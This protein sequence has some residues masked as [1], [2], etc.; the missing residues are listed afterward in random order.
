MNFKLR[1]VEGLIN[2]LLDKLV[3]DVFGL[4][5][6]LY[7]W[8]GILKKNLTKL[9]NCTS[10]YKLTS[11]KESTVTMWR[12]GST[13]VSRGSDKQMTHSFPGSVP[14]ASPPSNEFPIP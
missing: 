11:T 8:F 1:T 3:V 6:E 4:L 13:V 2:N 9:L 7:T 5:V 12:Q 10:G 14:S